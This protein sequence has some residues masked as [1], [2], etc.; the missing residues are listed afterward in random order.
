ML[1]HSF[2]LCPDCDLG[3]QRII[4]GTYGPSFLTASTMGH[5]TDYRIVG[6]TW[7]GEGGGG[8]RQVKE[9]NN[10]PNIVTSR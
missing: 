1:H 2:G 7:D 3:S 6:G 9:Q 10:S 5:Q 4:V 8:K